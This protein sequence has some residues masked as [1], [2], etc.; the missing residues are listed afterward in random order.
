MSKKLLSFMLFAMLIMAGAVRADSLSG[1]ADVTVVD[2]AIVSLRYEGTEYVVANGDLLLGATTRWY[3]VDGVETL[4]VEGDPAPAE[5]VSGTS[6]PKDGD[7]GS[8]ADNFLFALDGSPNI[9]SIDGIDFQ[10]TIF[11]APTDTVFLF[12]RGGNDAGTW[13]AILE[14]GSLGAEVAFDKASDG[15]PYADTGA[16]STSQGAYGVVFTTLTHCVR[17][18]A[19]AHLKRE[20]GYWLNR[21]R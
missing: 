16:K 10:E 11:A 3:V 21:V 18:I 2:G 17:V 8:K 7:V 1:L 4:W 9:S 14:D 6:N 20:P 12:E 19:F 13:Q 15:G 5:T